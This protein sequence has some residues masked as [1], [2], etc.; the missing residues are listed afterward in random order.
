M[1]NVKEMAKNFSGSTPK[2]L[3]PLL[4][5]SVALPLSIEASRIYKKDRKNQ[6][7]CL[8]TLYLYTGKKILN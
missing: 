3:H 7:R 8:T 1:Q 6:E 5:E 2:K 4:H